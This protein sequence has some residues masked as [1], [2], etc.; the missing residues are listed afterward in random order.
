MPQRL[1]LVLLAFASNAAA[2]ETVSLAKVVPPYMGDGLEM[3]VIPLPREAKLA[4]SMLTAAQILIEPAAKYA[5][6]ATLKD[7]LRWAAALSTAATKGGAI[8][9]V[10]LGEM[11]D[12][13]NAESIIKSV[14]LLPSPEKRAVMGD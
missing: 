13:S 1:F 7:A 14:G 2:L 8:V 11:G 4:E 5:H 3:A 6:P 12:G 10:H 9:K